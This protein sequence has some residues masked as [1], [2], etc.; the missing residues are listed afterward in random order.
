[1]RWALAIGDRV[2]VVTFDARVRRSVRDALV[3][4]LRRALEDLG[5]AEPTSSMAQTP[6]AAAG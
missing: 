1:V 2:P 6:E 5:P 3:M 4:L